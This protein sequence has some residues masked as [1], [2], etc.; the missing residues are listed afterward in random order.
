MNLS[1]ERKEALIYRGSTDPEVYMTVDDL[2]SLACKGFSPCEKDSLAT[3]DCCLSR[4]YSGDDACQCIRN[5]FPTPEYYELYQR[6]RE[7]YLDNL[8]KGFLLKIA[9]ETIQENIK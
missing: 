9:G 3:G 4:K 7:Y 2:V 1:K 6:L 8:G 5:I